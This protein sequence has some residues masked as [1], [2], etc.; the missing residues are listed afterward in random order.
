MVNINR[1]SQ[2]GFEEMALFAYLLRGWVAQLVN[3]SP[4]HRA[5]ELNAQ[6]L[7][8]PSDPYQGN[9]KTKRLHLQ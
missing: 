9:W 1:A 2:W 6:V 4:Y 3:I 7:S 5:F 8:D